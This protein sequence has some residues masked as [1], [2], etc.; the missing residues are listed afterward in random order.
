MLG[1]ISP[2]AYDMYSS[3]SDVLPVLLSLCSLLCPSIVEALCV[4]LFAEGA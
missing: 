1:F 4:V 3:N 2:F